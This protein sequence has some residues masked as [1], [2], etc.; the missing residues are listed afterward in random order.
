MT[1]K[2]LTKEIVETRFSDLAGDC[3]FVLRVERVE[4]VK[5]F[6]QEEPPLQVVFW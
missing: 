2:D 5:D 4:N 3:D 6:G 1:R